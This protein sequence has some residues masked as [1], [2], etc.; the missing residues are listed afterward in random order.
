M[1]RHSD[2][3]S[4]PEVLEAAA[5]MLMGEATAQGPSA[6]LLARLDYLSGP[7]ELAPHRTALLRAAAR[8]VRLFSLPAPDSP[9]LVA[10]GAELD[11]AIIG[12]QNMP[13]AGVSGTGLTFRQA[14]ESCVGEGVEYLSQFASADDVIERLTPAE[15]LS[16][17]APASRTLWEQLAPYRSNH[18]EAPINWTIAASLADGTPVRVPADMCF[19]RAAA[20]RDFIPP[21][22]LSIGCGAASDHLSATLHGLFELIERD[23]LAHWWRGGRRARLA[24]GDA[25]AVVLARL[26]GGDSPRRT[27]LLDITN[28]VRVPVAVAVSCTDSGFG[29]CCGHAARPSFQVAAEAAV[30]EMA[31]MEIA[32][33][34]S[35]A[36]RADQG[37]SALNE[38]DREHLRRF[39][40]VD[41]MRTPALQPLAPP[42]P[43]CD[44]PID[45]PLDT[46]LEVRKR[47]DALGLAPWVLNL[48]RAMFGIP[49]VRVICPGLE[50]GMTSPPGPRLRALAEASGVDPANVIPL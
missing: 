18:G 1:H 42:A 39:A 8:F 46:L 37:E 30:R 49:V 43:P 12:V 50:P 23:A 36:K 13:L 24:P 48:T 2:T 34:V 15:A 38:T 10:L 35:A 27:W 28:D 32:Y 14:F 31:Q 21:W 19:R 20:A 16:D 29:F 25:G 9:R 6:D 22:P 45:N 4:L 5:A 33:R 11:P 17:A 41:V 3:P 7:E 44:L 26:R 40:E 47:L